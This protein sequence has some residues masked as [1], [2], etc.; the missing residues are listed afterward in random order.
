ME[1]LQVLRV[2]LAPDEALRPRSSTP[3][4]VTVRVCANAVLLCVVCRVFEDWN[5]DDPPAIDPG[6]LSAYCR[7][8]DECKGKVGP[9]F[10]MG[11]PTRYQLY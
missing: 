8:R 4:S 10:R 2:R 9:P 7:V 5:L 3:A 11:L 1:E 6:D